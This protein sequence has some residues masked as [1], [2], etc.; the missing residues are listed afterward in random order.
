MIRPSVVYNLLEEI[1]R[2]TQMILCV[3][4]LTPHLHS[5]SHSILAL[6]PT[7]HQTTARIALGFLVRYGGLQA[8]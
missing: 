3:V 5:P 2:Q 8:C 4:V 6:I 1:E 7:H